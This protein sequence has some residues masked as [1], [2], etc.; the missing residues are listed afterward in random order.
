MSHNM[1]II[2]ETYEQYTS[3]SPRLPSK[4]RSTMTAQLNDHLLHLFFLL[5][6]DQDALREVSFVPHDISNF[7]RWDVTLRQNPEQADVMYVQ[8]PG[9]LVL[10][11]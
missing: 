4:P 10:C 9:A 8:D 3:I 7:R 2:E 5:I 1:N 6:Y 11:Y